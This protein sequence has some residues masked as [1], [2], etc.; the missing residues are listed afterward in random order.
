MRHR[1]DHRRALVAS[2]AV[3]TLVAGAAAGAELPVP[4]ASAGAKRRTLHISES[5]FQVLRVVEDEG[6]GER[7][8][9]NRECDFV[10]GAMSL[11]DPDTLVLEYTRSALVALAFL[12]R[13]P[14][15][16]LCLGLGTGSLPRF[17]A[18]RY[19]EAQVDVVEIDPAVPPVAKSFFRFRTGTRLRV[20]VA[21]AADFVKDRR[22]RYDLVVLD[23]AFGPDP[24]QQLATK[25]FFEDLRARTA[26][27]GVVVANLASAVLSPRAAVLPSR[28]KAALGPVTTFQTASPANLVAVGGAP[29]PEAR[30]LAE[31][32]EAIMAERRP[33]F[34]L[35]RLVHDMPRW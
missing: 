8:L 33:G 12:P 3:A 21:D 2:W 32:L 34:D 14:R 5:T 9:C 23:A 30:V 7:L 26:P 6:R 11:A 1:G 16:I 22:D 4:A 19:P 17:L 31:R 27:G 29:L 24:P 25:A 15:S 18:S 13:A 20:H 10:Q 28:M 35:A